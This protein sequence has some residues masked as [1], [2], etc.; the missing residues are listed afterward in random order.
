VVVPGACVCGIIAALMRWQKAARSPLSEQDATYARLAQPGEV[1][2]PGLI[3]TD[4]SEYLLAAPKLGRKKATY[5]SKVFL[6][7]T[8]RRL[9]VCKL[10][11]PLHEIS[12]EDVLSVEVLPPPGRELLATKLM[13]KLYR[14]QVVRIRY[15]TETGSVLVLDY[16]AAIDTEPFAATLRDYVA[17]RKDRRHGWP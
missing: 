11:Y 16:D 10:N 15:R 14:V 5:Q 1:I 17:A 3:A 2:L 12:L 7:L 13:Q 6:Y 8:D 9:I 4:W